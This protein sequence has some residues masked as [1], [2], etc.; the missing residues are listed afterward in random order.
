MFERGKKPSEG[1]FFLPLYSE[2]HNKQADQNKRVWKKN[3]S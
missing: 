1:I 2:L 3:S